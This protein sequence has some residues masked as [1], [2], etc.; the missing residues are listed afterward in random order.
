MKPIFR[1]FSPRVAVFLLPCIFLASCATAPR[2]IRNT[3]LAKAVALQKS[4]GSPLRDPQR[5]IV[6]QLRAAALAS[7][8]SSRST[9]AQEICKT[10]TA[11]I[12]GWVVNNQ[13]AGTKRFSYQ[14]TSYDLSLTSG[15]DSFPA[16]AFES[17][18]PASEV[19]RTLVKTWQ[20]R[21]GVGAPLAA[22]WKPPANPEKA[23]FVAPRGYIM[24]VTAWLDFSQKTKTGGT[25]KVQLQFL[26]PT[27]VEDVASNGKMQP[28]AAD[29]SA[30]LVDRTRDIREL[31]IALEGL[32]HPDAHDASLRIMEPY[33]PSRTP[34]VFIHGLMSHPRMW[35]DV[36]NDL[37]ADPEIAAKYQFWVYYYPTGWPIGY[38]AMRLREELAGADKA[39]GKQKRLVLVGH[40]MGGLL[41][42]MQAISPG[43]SIIHAM[44]PKDR[45][46]KFEKLPA[47]H[48][49]RKSM[50]FRANPAVERIVF[51][52]TPHRGSRI[53]DW[54]LSTWFTKFIH[55]PSKV[56]SAAVDLLPSLVKSPE[57]YSSISRL[58]PSNPLYK[59]L[60]PIPI[61]APHHSIIGDRGRGDTP[62]SSDG[63]VPCWSS[64]LDSAESEVIVPD[65]H[66]AFDDPAAI[67]ELK[68]ILKENLAARH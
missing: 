5:Y 1:P 11:A 37:M 68:R 21:P 66:G 30:P 7:S 19:P 48:I 39:F 17:V 41:A 40:S 64:H 60:E 8:E 9:Q 18:K 36:I 55:M 16:T 25:E 33:D 23:K 26:D 15:H 52:C 46:E 4:A 35:R 31:L 61:R 14:G 49:G 59:V 20:A 3:P 47:N 2:E 42:R 44:I 28:L 58:S 27:K 38:S 12:A 29:F 63:V 67:A 54:S 57:Q 65:D 51:I 22:R 50:E 53:A 13:Q 45:W 24:P 6:S 43:K 34:V 62:D 32:I 56:T 10:S